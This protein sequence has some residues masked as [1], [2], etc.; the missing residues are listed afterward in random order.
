MNYKQTYNELFSNKN[1]SIHHEDEFRYQVAKNFIK[2]RNLQSII[3]VG[4]GRGVFLKILEKE[5]PNIKIL[6]TN[7]EKYNENNFEFQSID[8]SNPASFSNITQTYDVLTCLDVIEHL[9]KHTI[10][11]VFKWFSQI[12]FFQILTIANHSE[13]WNGKEI[14]LIQEGV[15]Y[16]KPIIEKHFNILHEQIKIFPNNNQL[17]LFITSNKL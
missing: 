7:L 5:I 13:I 8:L 1:Y 17:Y 12:S 16:W 10:E 3:D 6:S 15:T 4:S 11:A 2:E 14:H 9:E